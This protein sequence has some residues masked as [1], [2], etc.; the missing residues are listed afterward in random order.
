MEEE[1]HKF[2]IVNDQ[3]VSW[4]TA[5]ICL[6]ENACYLTA[7]DTE[8]GYEGR[9]Y[10]TSLVRDLIKYLKER[11]LKFIYLDDMSN[12]IP[13][14]NIYYKLGFQIIGRRGQWIK[15]REHSKVNGPERRMVLY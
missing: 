13:P 11:N 7:L 9:G 8:I 10:A 2:I 4:C 5:Y 14:R 12:G 3:Q 1:Y 6:E 15:W